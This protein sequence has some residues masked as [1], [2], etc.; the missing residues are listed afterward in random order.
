MM[1][2]V[3]KGKALEDESESGEICGEGI[4]AGSGGICDEALIGNTHDPCNL[5]MTLVSKILCQ[6]ILDESRSGPCDPYNLEMTSVL[7]PM[8]C[9]CCWS[10]FEKKKKLGNDTLDDN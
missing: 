10:D 6:R 3:D 8:S 1:T 5:E 4:L 7:S 9:Q 2:L